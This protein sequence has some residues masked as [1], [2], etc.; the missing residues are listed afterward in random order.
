[1][2]P[3]RW[4]VAK[5]F[6][7]SAFPTIPLLAPLGFYVD[8]PW[9]TPAVVLIGIPVSDFMLRKD[10]SGPFGRGA[11]EA[12]IAWLHLIPYLYVL[13]WAGT[14]AWALLVLQIN[15]IPRPTVAWLILSVSIGS[16]FATCAAH[17]LLHW[18]E[19]SARAVAR[20]VMAT[21]AYGH[22]PIEHLNHHVTL[23][24]TSG[25]TTPLIGQSVWSFLVSNAV[26]SFRSAWRTERRRHCGKS[27]P[28]LRNRF[29]Q[30]LFLTSLML[31]VF[32][33]VAGTLGL[34]LFILQAASGIYTTEYVN[35][36]QHYGLSRVSEAPLSGRLS[37]SSNAFATNAATLN[38][39]RHADHHLR[40]GVRYYDLEHMEGVPLLPA[41][42]LALFIPA[43]IPPL[44]RRLM[45]KRASLFTKDHQQ[46]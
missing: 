29:V 4:R 31:I 2:A 8:V 46:Q 6:A 9:L 25:G 17:E 33:S 5:F 7:F 20:L 15:E 24:L 26:F 14:L 44:W 22:F 11:S 35:Y 32:T 45:D 42:Y 38:I 41:G 43:M 21:V 37:W 10:E 27:L 30:Q 16:A 12:T 39:T 28:L 34:L 40:A 19:A 23:G 36:A 1:M 13:V 18:P 3:L